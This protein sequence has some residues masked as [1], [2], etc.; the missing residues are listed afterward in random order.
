MRARACVR[1]WVK[2]IFDTVT[3]KRG[4][5]PNEHAAVSVCMCGR[6][7]GWVGVVCAGGGGLLVRARARAREF[8]LTHKG[9]KL[10]QATQTTFV[11]VDAKRQHKILHV[12]DRDATCQP[13]L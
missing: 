8:T 11:N 1:G 6:V 10:D 4:V 9:R 2:A 5:A 12:A 13:R 7:C 3:T